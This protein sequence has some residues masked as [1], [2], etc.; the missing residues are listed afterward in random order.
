GQGGWSED[1]LSHQPA[2]GRQPLDQVDR[3]QIDDAARLRG[4]NRRHDGRIKAIGI[5][6]E[7]IASAGGNAL[8]NAVDAGAVQIGC[9]DQLRAAFERRLYFLRPCAALSTQTDLEDL[10]EMRHLGGAPDR[11][12]ISL[13]RAVYTL[14]P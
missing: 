12:R 9:R 14:A 4:A 3:L 13:A 8:E 11:A 7:V 1:V 6:A 2:F 10:F 5:D